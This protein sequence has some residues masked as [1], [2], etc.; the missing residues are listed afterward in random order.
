MAE[1]FGRAVLDGFPLRL[2]PRDALGN[3]AVLDAAFAS[4]RSG[5]PA[6][7]ARSR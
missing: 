6:R 4:L 1:H 5:R 2:T 3:I 7:V